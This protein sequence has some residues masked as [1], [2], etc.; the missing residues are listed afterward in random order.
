[1]KERKKERKIVNPIPKSRII[2]NIWLKG[3][4]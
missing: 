3:S 1:M 4:V 2:E